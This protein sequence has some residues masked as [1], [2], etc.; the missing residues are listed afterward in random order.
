MTSLSFEIS[1]KQLQLEWGKN[2]SM[3]DTQYK[4]RK[5]IDPVSATNVVN[6][7]IDRLL[8]P[9]YLTFE[10]EYFSLYENLSITASPIPVR[11]YILNYLDRRNNYSNKVIPLIK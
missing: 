5:E 7:N 6:V 9:D 2:E 4:T 8:S 3:P 11:G 1:K 10:N